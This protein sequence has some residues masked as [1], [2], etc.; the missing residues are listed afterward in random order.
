MIYSNI[1]PAMALIRKVAASQRKTLP[2]FQVAAEHTC[3]SRR[4]IDY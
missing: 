2:E 4:L 3:G 1:A